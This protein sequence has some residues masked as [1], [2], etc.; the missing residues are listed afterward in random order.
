MD[1]LSPRLRQLSADIDTLEAAVGPLLLENNQAAASLRLPLLDRAKLQVLASYA[2]ESTLFSSLG[3]AGVNVHDHAV[4]QELQRVRGYIEKIS[5][6]EK[7]DANA[8]PT[9]RLD[10]TAAIRF[11]RAEM[12]DPNVRAQLGQLEKKEAAAAKSG[13]SGSG[14]GSGNGNNSNTAAHTTRGRKRGGGPGAGSGD[15]RD[16]GSNLAKR[17]KKGGRTV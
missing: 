7:K 4:R 17:P 8:T 13:G 11:V 15:R 5:A 2:L 3:L 6:I 14:N 10:K 1:D 16:G 12:D 9:S